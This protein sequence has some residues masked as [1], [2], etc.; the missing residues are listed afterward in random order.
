MLIKIANAL[1]AFGV[2]VVLS[3]ALS[4]PGLAKAK[5]K[6]SHRAKPPSPYVRAY[7]P[8]APIVRCRHGV[9]DPYGLRCDDP[10]GD[11]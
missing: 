3:L 9:W 10:V 4:S 1:M 8:L 6:V 5:A 11:R 7:V 2:A